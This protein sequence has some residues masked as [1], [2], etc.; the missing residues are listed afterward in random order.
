MA[1]LDLA[2][3]GGSIEFRASDDAVP[4]GVAVREQR[5]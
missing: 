1:H 3:C 2:A 5:R 4:V